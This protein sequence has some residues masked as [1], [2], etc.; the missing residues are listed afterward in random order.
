MARQL[1]IYENAVPVSAER[2]R[3]LWVKGGANFAFA[4]DLNSVPL[5][6]AEI[7]PAGAEYPV[8][9]VGENPMPVMLAG[10]REGENLFVDDAGAWTGRYV[11]AF[12]RRYPFVFATP[13]DGKTYTLCI[14]EGFA[15]CNRAGRGEPLFDAE[16]RRTQFLETA[17]E[18]TRLYQAQH[19]L[20]LA[21]GRRLKALDLLEP[22]QADFK[23]KAGRQM[24]LTGFNTVSRMK[25]KA[26]PGETLA[27]LMQSDGLE[28]IYLHLGSLKHLDALVDLVSE[29]VV[30]R[31]DG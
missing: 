30:R 3:D 15:G 31:T 28:L 6:I 17:L 13:T 7:P 1:L 20:T 12:L 19:E 11:P 21:F 18:F 2:H 9:F 5:T 29:R 4:M 14:D 22:M 10:A 24:R 16:G 26:L 23:L 25:L 8:V 27:E